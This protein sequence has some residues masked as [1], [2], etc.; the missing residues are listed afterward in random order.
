MS[1]I[2]VPEDILIN[3]LLRLPFKSISL[4]RC[5]CKF[6]R[7]LLSNRN[8]VKTHYDLAV[9]KN[10]PNTILREYV[11]S[12]QLIYSLNMSASECEIKSIDKLCY[13][14]ESKGHVEILGS[15]NGL[16]CIRAGECHDESTICIWN[17]TTK[18][19]KKVPRS[20]KNQFPSDLVPEIYRIAYGLWYDSKIDDFKLI[21]VVGFDGDS[22][23]SGVQVYNLGLNSWS[24]HELIPYY[25]TCNTM[26]SGIIVHGSLHWLGK[27]GA[28]SFVQLCPDVIV[29]FD[30]C[31]ERFYELTFPAAVNNQDFSVGREIGVL[32][33]CLCLI[34][35]HSSNGQVDLWVMREHGVKE[36]WSILFTTHALHVDYPFMGVNTGG[37]CDMFGRGDLKTTRLEEHREDG[38]LEK[39]FANCNSSIPRGYSTGGAS[40]SVSVKLL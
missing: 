24:T 32:D 12:K 9:E 3:I 5:V 38:H 18:E 29:S 25:V 14:F 13:P 22:T 20:P 4:C 15:S 30:I 40:I 37:K 33:G 6:W 17:P 11:N 39:D 26:R 2:P 7:T 21:K 31:D 36:S 8:F 28:K 19:Y 23:R 10:Y 27:A 16:L 1:S 34:L 35:R